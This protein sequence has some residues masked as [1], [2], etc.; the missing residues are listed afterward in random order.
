MTDRIEEIGLARSKNNDQWYYD[1][2]V[3]TYGILK[4]RLCTVPESSG[5]WNVPGLL[6]KQIYFPE[7]NDSKKCWHGKNYYDCNMQI[8]IIPY[9]CKWWHFY[10]SQNFDEHIEKFNE[11]T[12]NTYNINFGN[13]FTNESFNRLHPK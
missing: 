8:R 13:I 7:L 11:I 9:G 4:N 3:T 2:W 6:D 1:Q 5:L 10:P 12:N